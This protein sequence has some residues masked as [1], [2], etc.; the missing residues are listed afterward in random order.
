MFLLKMLLH[1]KSKPC[2]S[3]ISLNEVMEMRRS[4]ALRVI[5]MI[6]PDPIAMCV[7]LIAG[8]F[9]LG[10]ISGHL[11]AKNCD[12][13][14]QD[15]FR[16][17]LSDCCLWFEQAG[18]ILS[19]WRTILL[20]FGIVC[21]TFLFGFS[22]L[23]VILIPFFSVGIGFTSFYTVSCFVQA[24]GKTGTMLAAALTGVRLFFLVPSFFA[25]A[26]AA[27]Q[28]SFR[29][30]SLM[31]GHGKRSGRLPLGGQCVPVFVICLVCL[32]VGVICERLLTPILFR[33][34][35]GGMEL[36]Y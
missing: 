32:C 12:A 36:I 18:V 21:V 24:F 25:V 8:C 9:L 23:G 7:L 4:S 29:L 30:S 13:A 1:P 20:Y 6:S 3:S 22:S 28:N 11:Y 17:Y 10:G 15:A 14:A 34:V 33:A 27:L 35:I 5:R 16:Q 26:S 31:L 19:P 2:P